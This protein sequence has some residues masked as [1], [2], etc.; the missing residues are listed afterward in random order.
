MENDKDPKAMEASSTSGTQKKIMDQQKPIS[1]EKPNF[2][3]LKFYRKT[4]FR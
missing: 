4:H 1:S 2:Q 3:V